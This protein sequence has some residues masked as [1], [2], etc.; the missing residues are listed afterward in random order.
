MMLDI[1]VSS[2]VGYFGENACVDINQA[3]QSQGERS[4]YV[5]STTDIFRL[6]KWKA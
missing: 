4:Y 2:S 6:S 3:E 1:V 5:R